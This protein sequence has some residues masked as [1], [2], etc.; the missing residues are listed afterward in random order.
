MI[1]PDLIQAPD[2]IGDDLS[3]TNAAQ[4]S[5]A[6][7]WRAVIGQAAHDC[8]WGDQE[9]KVENAQWLFTEDFDVVCTF[10]CVEPKPIKD[11]FHKILT[12]EKQIQARYWARQ[13]VKC[14]DYFDEEIDRHIYS[15]D[16]DPEPT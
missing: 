4:T 15:M 16:P 10:A 8:V 9:M 5:E 7:L 13:L 14:F 6:R 12:A 3:R 11:L 2:A 1:D